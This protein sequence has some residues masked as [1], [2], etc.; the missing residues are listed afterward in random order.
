M[1]LPSSVLLAP[2]FAAWELGADIPGIPSD[3]LANLSRLAAWL[4]SVRGKLGVPLDIKSGYRSPTHNAEVG[5]S[6]TSDHP[7]GLAA[8]FKARGLAMWTVY[9]RLKQDDVPAFDQVI[10]YPLDGHIHVGLGPKMR[11][12]FRLHLAEGGYPLLT[13]ETIDKLGGPSAIGLYVLA[14]G[15]GLFLLTRKGR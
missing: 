7:N 12:E 8:D 10:F 6:A 11:G 4:E 2:H 13:Q 3:A 15:V 14:I 5:G 9:N 1:S